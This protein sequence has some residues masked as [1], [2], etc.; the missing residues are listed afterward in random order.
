MEF[1]RPLTTACGQVEKRSFHA[2]RSPRPAAGQPLWVM[3]G[4]RVSALGSQGPRV[5][6]EA[7]DSAAGFKAATKHPEQGKAPRNT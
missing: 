5:G 3:R 6:S 7:P 2:A 1:L 4:L